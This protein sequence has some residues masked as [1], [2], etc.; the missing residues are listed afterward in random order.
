MSDTALR[1]KLID[2][3]AFER[4]VTLRLPFRFGVVTLREAPQ[5]FIRARI[6]L[7]DGREGEGVS[8]ELLVP[9]WFDKSSKLSNEDNFNQLRRAVAI[10]HRHMMAVG[11]QTAFG[12]SAHADAGHRKEAEAA[13]LNGLV[14]SFGLALIER[15]IIDALGRLEGAS[16]ADLVRGNRLGIGKAL[17]PDLASFDLDTYLGGVT[18]ADTIFARHTVGLVDA[19]TRADTQGK[20]LDDGLPE[21]LE[22]VIAAYGHVYFKLKVGG[23]ADA[24]I[25]RLA[26]IASVLDAGAPYKATLDGNEQYE[27]V[28][29]VLEL[30]RRIGEDKRLARLKASLLLIEQ[31]IMRSEAL[32]KP[33]HALAKDI[34]VEIDESDA[35]F[36]VFP[37]A[38]ALGYQGISA[39]SCKGF[40]RALLNS[41]RVAH[42]NDQYG[43]GFLMSAEDLTTQGGI[44]VQQDLLL[45]SLVGATHIERNGHHYV[46]GMAGAP[47]GEQ[48]SYLAVHGDLYKRA[49]NGR[50][51]LDIN[52]GSI[53]LRTIAQ[54]HGL[55][56]AVVPDWN[57]M[58]ASPKAE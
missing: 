11:E 19:I 8:A 45:A 41:A 24:D 43:G 20:R 35:D 49:D 31:P 3:A 9:K 7:A 42:Y 30:W 57:L 26:Q 15:A 29:A 28:D 46:D 33:V 13:G 36:D 34:A 5:I 16:A 21:S 1:L 40:Y 18:P 12:I 50:A 55:G 38:R 44:A 58:N 23:Q 53:S 27:N 22:E 14:A 10:A 17:T 25:E 32:N 54:A 48:E 51:Q 4:P 39:K 47:Q 2:V 6:K 37:R 52:N 56:S